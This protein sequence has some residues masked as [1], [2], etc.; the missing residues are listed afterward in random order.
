MASGLFCVQE[1]SSVE[2]WARS[3]DVVNSF[4]DWA[5]GGRRPR[6]CNPWLVQ[7]RW[8]VGAR[9]VLDHTRTVNYRPGAVHYSDVRV[10]AVLSMSNI[11]N[12]TEQFKGLR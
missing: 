6:Y 10:L 8:Q 11:Q 12:I 2:T 4:L 5:A 9:D 7:V 3:M 1:G